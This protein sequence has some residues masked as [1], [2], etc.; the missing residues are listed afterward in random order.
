VTLTLWSGGQS[1]FLSGFIFQYFKHFWL[2]SVAALKSIVAHTP[3]RCR[4]CLSTKNEMR[5]QN[6]LAAGLEANETDNHPL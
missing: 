4:K 5:T 3:W 1:S 6:R 2:T